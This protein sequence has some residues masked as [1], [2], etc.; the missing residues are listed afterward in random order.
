MTEVAKGFRNLRVTFMQS[1]EQMKQQRQAAADLTKNGPPQ[2]TSNP[3]FG[4]GPITDVAADEVEARRGRFAFEHWLERNYR[5]LDDKGR[6]IGSF[7]A[8]EVGRSMHRGYPADKIIVDMMREIHRYFEFPMSNHMAV[9]L[10]G[11]HSGFSV[12]ML[13]LI[14]GGDESQ[15][16]YIDTPRPESDDAS[17]GGFF[18]QSWGAQIIEMMRFAKG[19]NE[20]RLHFSATDGVIPSASALCAKNIKL[21][22]G[23]GHETTGATTYT[24]DDIHNLIAWLDADPINHHAILDATSLLGAM[25]W[26]E[27]LVKQMTAKCCFF[28]PFQKAIGGI[29]GYFVITFT[30]QA[31]VLVAANAKTPV[32]AIPR[33]M[34]LANPVDPKKPLSGERTVNLGPFYDP[35]NDK[36]LGGVINTFSTLAFAETVFGLQRAAERVGSVASMNL[37]SARNRA[38]INDWLL[39]SDWLEA[40]VAEAERRGAAVTLLKVRDVGIDDPAIHA[41]IIA[42]SKQ[43]LSYDGITHPNG[44]H[45]TGLDVA[46]YVNAF[47]GTPGDYR[48][49]IGGI[50]EVS[51]IVA[52]L[53]NVQYAYL[54]AKIV[55]LEEELEKLGVAFPMENKSGGGAHTNAGQLQLHDLRK[56]SEDVTAILAAFDST[57]QP[58]MTNLQID[59]YKTRLLESADRLQALLCTL[60]FPRSGD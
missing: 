36:M 10:G 46:R 20:R 51:D 7:S 40:G 44:Q 26:G 42:K 19:G 29:A 53:E 2:R 59:R 31:L 25:P 50:R 41:R 33:Q 1:I 48:A 60:E 58:M 43:L 12:A 28:M 3:F 27:D 18:R 52:L 39:T 49:W 35:A 17:K 15:H 34:K 57:S 55:V 13:H 54:R 30:P 38:A 11:G 45:E 14:T 22:F 6:D 9:G 21:V 47:P 56:C 8:A 37:R 16:I 24:A 32:A 5:K 23:V 4:V